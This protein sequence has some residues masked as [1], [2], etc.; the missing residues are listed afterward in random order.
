MTLPMYPEGLVHFRA[1]LVAHG[2]GPR[3]RSKRARAQ[4]RARGR[5]CSGSARVEASQNPPNSKEGGG[6]E[7]GNTRVHKT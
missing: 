2:L 6:G 1:Q 7:K 4:A 5:F 3:R